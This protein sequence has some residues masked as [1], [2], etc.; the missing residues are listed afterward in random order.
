MDAWEVNSLSFI[1]LALS[2]SK[3]ISSRRIEE[4]EYNTFMD[5]F[6]LGVS[7]SPLVAI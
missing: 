6:E 5:R 7:I 2:L 3:L 4:T 1:I